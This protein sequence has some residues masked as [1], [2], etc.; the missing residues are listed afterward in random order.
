MRKID[1]SYQKNV[2]DLGGLVGFNGKKVKFG[3]LYRG[4]FL[5]RVS[6]NDIKLINS[7]RLTDIVDFRSSVEYLSR[8]DYVFMGVKYHNF[9]ALDESND[10]NLKTKND[11]DDS[12]LLWFLGE[13]VDG[14][15][16]MHRIYPEL[17][18]T[19]KGIEAYKNFF[20]VLLNENR[21]VY[22]H[23]SQGKDRAGLA[24]FLLEIALGVSLEDAKTDYL[25]TNEA[26][27]DKIITYKQMLKDKPYYNV[28]YEQALIDVFSA[29]IEY[30]NHAIEEVE[31]HYGSV[32]SYI[33]NILEVD[34]NRLRKL[35]LE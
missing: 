10:D 12:N 32:L 9:P 15:G 28:D 25:L 6:D 17:L 22:F 23:C 18:L 26:M 33:K 1:L 3:R 4:G 7:L 27:E 19:P 31:R 20:K 34:V 30:L 35:Y 16:H 2:R 5:G 11:F 29:R 14:F 21:V 8:P 13:S 24:S